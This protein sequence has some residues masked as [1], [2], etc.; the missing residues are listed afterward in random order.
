MALGPL[1]LGF[2]FGFG[3]GLGLGLELG[4][5]L[6]NLP[7]ELDGEPARLSAL[8]R[9]DHRRQEGQRLLLQCGLHPLQVVRDGAEERLEG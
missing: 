5:G 1:G 8:D 7:L 3:F 2:R 6:G 4:L 9:A